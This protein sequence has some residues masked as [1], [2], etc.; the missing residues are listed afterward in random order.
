MHSAFVDYPLS[1]L[2]RPSGI[3]LSLPPLFLSLSFVLALVRLFS[4]KTQMSAQMLRVSLLGVG[5]LLRLERDA[6]SMAT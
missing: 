3:S 2:S 1:G 5:T 6:W 4:E